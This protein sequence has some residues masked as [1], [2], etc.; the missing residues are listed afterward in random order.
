VAKL[1]KEE[2]ENVLD[3]LNEME[4]YVVDSD[5]DTSWGEEHEDKVVYEWQDFFGD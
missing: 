2:E 4:T 1:R 3:S 5:S